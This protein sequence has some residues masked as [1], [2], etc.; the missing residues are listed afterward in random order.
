M[1][2]ET[3]KTPAVVSAPHIVLV[4]SDDHGFNDVGWHNDKVVTPH[5]DK[6]AREGIRLEQHYSQSVCTPSR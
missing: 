3:L 4:L 2:Q 5:L 6:L 1:F